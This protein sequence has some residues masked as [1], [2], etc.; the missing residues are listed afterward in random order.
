LAEPKRTDSSLELAAMVAQDPKLQ[1]QIRQ[2][3]TGT[4][5]S[6]SR[7]LDTDR[8]VYRIVVLALGLTALLVVLGAIVLTALDKG[9][10][11]DAL[12]AIGSA[13][14]AA[15]AALLAPSPRE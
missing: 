15:L 9:N 13:A 5:Q 14:I 7:P 6:L 3:P 11:P 10:I 8:W 1:A 2:D 12:V 4:L